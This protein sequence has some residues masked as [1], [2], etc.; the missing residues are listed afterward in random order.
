[1]RSP[2]LKL[3]RSKIHGIGIFGKRNINKGEVL[4]FLKGNVINYII[5]D[6][7]KAELAGM[8]WCGIGKNK[9]IDPI[10]LAKYI[11]H[12]CNPNAGIKG[13]V[14]VVALKNIKKNEEITF[15]YSTTEADVFWDFQCS[16]KNRNC[17]GNIK[18]IQFLSK[19]RFSHYLP[20]IPLHFQKL[21]FRFNISN[22]KDTEE[23]IYNYVNYLTTNNK[24]N[25]YSKS[26]KIK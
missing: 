16:Y 18:S 8:D 24:K 10:G 2:K 11:N 1:M 25:T 6:E 9:W 22:F 13:K 21:F 20:F 5:S 23:L 12:S 4:F 19:K 3:E 7:E 15:D 17:R 26:I 14:T